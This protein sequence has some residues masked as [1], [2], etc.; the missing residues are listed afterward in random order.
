[1]QSQLTG[2]RSHGLLFLLAAMYAEIFLGRQILAVM[3]EP[4]KREFDASDTAMGL[5]SGLAFAG[6]YALLGLPAGR[7]A[8]RMPRTRLLAVSCLLWGL[9]TLFCGLAGSFVVLVIARMVVAV[10]ESPA[11]PASIALIADIYPPHQRSFAISCFTAAPT[12]AGIIGLGAG[13]W[14]VEHYGWRSAFLAIALPSLVIAAMLAFVVRDPARGRWDPAHVHAMQPVQSMLSIAHELFKQPPYRCLMLASAITS[15]ST[16][17]LV[18]WNTS[19][20]MRSH[21][22][23]LQHAGL[24]AGLV[25]GSSAG[26]GVLFSGWLADRLAVRNQAWKIGI[27]LVGHVFGGCALV[28]YLLWPNDILMHIA[29]IP[30]PSAMLWSAVASFFSVWWVG[31]SYSLLTQLIA[32]N[33]RATAMAV[34]TIASTLLGVGIGPFAVG[35]LSDALQPHFGVESLRYALVLISCTIVIPVF[36]LWRTYQYTYVDPKHSLPLAWHN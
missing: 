24:L 10:S 26:V 3:I 12:F 13:A 14:M 5:I 7:L 34:Q 33:R 30:V 21:D 29:S 28:T 18:M 19:F 11:T 25:G 23:P 9:A 16:Y 15:L 8:D 17:A 4:I 2:W 22:L 36:L 6:V 31:P 35:L 27:P 32:P 1:M 20:L